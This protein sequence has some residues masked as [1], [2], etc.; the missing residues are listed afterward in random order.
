ME[1]VSAHEV[2][3]IIRFLKKNICR[4]YENP[5]KLLLL[6]YYFLERV[7]G[8]KQE[9]CSI[10]ITTD[11]SQ[12]YQLRREWPLTVKLD[13]VGVESH[14]P[15][16]EA[17]SGILVLVESRYQL[18]QISGSSFRGLLGNFTHGLGELE[19]GALF[20]RDSCDIAQLGNQQ[21]GRRHA[22]VAFS[23]LGLRHEKWLLRILYVNGVHFL[24]VSK[25]NTNV[26]VAHSQHKIN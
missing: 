13:Q 26:K 5:K 21:N 10:D 24:V 15:I 8:R 6:L 25:P 14:I 12:H 9:R 4:E 19:V 2:D 7:L 17:L 22:S 11:V 16:L 1:T 23:L 18:F 20:I 3:L